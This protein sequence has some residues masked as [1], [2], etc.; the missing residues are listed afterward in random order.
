[1]EQMLNIALVGRAGS[2][3]STLAKKIAKEFDLVVID[4]SMLK[5]YITNKKDG[6]EQMQKTMQCGGQVDEEL[7][8]KALAIKVASNTSCK[9]FIWD[10]LYTIEGYNIAKEYFPINIAFYLEIDEQSA[11]ERLHD[12]CR[13]DFNKEFIQNRTK[14][15]EENLPKLK[16]ALGARLYTIAATISTIKVFSIAVKRISS[17]I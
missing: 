15:F 9:G 14:V 5:E 3:K 12:R 1:M 2:G 11:N 13:N 8:K 10:N 17:L 7:L 16:E 6:Y 4:S